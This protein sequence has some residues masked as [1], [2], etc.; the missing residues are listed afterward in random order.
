MAINQVRSRKNPTVILDFIH[1]ARFSIQEKG[2]QD[3]SS[4]K[5]FA[6]R[7]KRKAERN[8]K[9][10]QAVTLSLSPN[11]ET[12]RQQTSLL[13]LFESR[14]LFR[15]SPGQHR[16]RFPQVRI[17]S[18]SLC[19]GNYTGSNAP[20]KLRCLYCVYSIYLSKQTL[21]HILPR[22]RPNVTLR[23]VVGYGLMRLPRVDLLRQRIKEKVHL[24]HRKEQAQFD[25]LDTRASSVPRRKPEHDW[26]RGD[27]QRASAQNIPESQTRTAATVRRSG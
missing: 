10:S 15:S 23:R 14:G 26:E 17:A 27:I 1:F 5:K 18:H 13:T 7:L 6:E 9:T 3:D 19:L 12:R 16:Q 11:Q 22:N 21:L 2:I 25:E 4:A 20:N 8:I 24:D